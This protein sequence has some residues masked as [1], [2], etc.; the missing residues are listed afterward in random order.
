M[1]QDCVK[2]A[3]PPRNAAIEPAPIERRGEGVGGGRAEQEGNTGQSWS[4]RK[5]GKHGGLA[6]ENGIKGNQMEK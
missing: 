2:D 5:R 1:N 4:G 6:E 3:A